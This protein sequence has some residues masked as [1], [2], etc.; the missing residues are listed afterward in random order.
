MQLGAKAPQQCQ[1]RACSGRLPPTPG[2]PCHSAALV[3][4]QLGCWPHGR[5]L[6][7]EPTVQEPVLRGAVSAG[8]QRHVLLQRHRNSAGC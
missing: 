5:A 6:A 8:A 3:T 7:G 2:N 4:A 1:K